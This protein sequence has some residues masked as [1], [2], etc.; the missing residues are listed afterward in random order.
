MYTHIKLSVN[1]DDWRVNMS[2]LLTPKYY[3]VCFLKVR[4]FP[5]VAQSYP[6]LQPHGLQHARLPCP[7]STPRAYSNSVPPVSDAIQ[8]SH[9]LSSP[10]P[11]T[12]NLSQHH[13]LSKESSSH[14]VAKVLEFQLQ[15]QS[16]Q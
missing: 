8:Q 13:G 1:H 2:G 11:P 3:N 5:S 15:H 10:S 14:H 16:F 6:T 7:L 9:P 12:F 4:I